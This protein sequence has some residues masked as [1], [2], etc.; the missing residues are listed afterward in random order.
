MDSAFALPL[1]TL[2]L[3]VGLVE[4]PPVLLRVTFSARLLGRCS[5]LAPPVLLKLLE[6]RLRSLPLSR[7][8]RTNF[9]TPRRT[10][11]T[12]ARLSKKT[13]SFWP[14]ESLRT[15][16][17]KCC[18]ISGSILARSI[19][20]LPDSLNNFR[21]MRS[22]PP[23]PPPPPPLLALLLGLVLEV[24]A[25]LLAAALEFTMRIL[26]SMSLGSSPTIAL[27]DGAAPSPLSRVSRIGTATAA[28][29][30]GVL[31]FRWS[32]TSMT[33][34]IWC[35]RSDSEGNLPFEVDGG[36]CFGAPAAVADLAPVLFL[37][38]CAS[39][40]DPLRVS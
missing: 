6:L 37:L 35:R 14:L 31:G 39:C 23:P 20:V 40:F 3:L 2:I 7:V 28:E 19:S 9:R 22:S 4:L 21:M 27:A 10:T 25:V 30:L 17:L 29:G 36:R 26:R 18:F 33:G 32:F 8:S 13:P 11:S 1:L 5:R 12:P 34:G 38:N 16:R 24:L 15:V